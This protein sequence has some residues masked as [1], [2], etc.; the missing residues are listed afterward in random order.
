M[1]VASG[2]ILGYR[3]GLPIVLIEYGQAIL[4]LLVAVLLF[5]PLGS[6]WQGLIGGYSA[7]ANVSALVAL[8]VMSEMVLMIATLALMRRHA[9]HLV[10]GSVNPLSRAAGG[11]AG[12]VKLAVLASAVIILLEAL[13]LSGSD[14]RVLFRSQ[15]TRASLASSNPVSRLLHGI[16]GDDLRHGLGL[17]TIATDPADNKIVPLN[18]TTTGSPDPASESEML[19][20]VN[21]ERQR[22]GLNSLTVN[23]EAQTVARAYAVDMFAG[24]YFSHQGRDGSTPF[25]R[26][27][28]NKV[29][30]GYA[31]ENLA[32]APQVRA[33]H[34][35]LMESPPHRANILSKNYRTVGIGIIKSPRYGIMVVQVFTD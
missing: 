2:I 30:F 20:L 3:R 14:Q 13:P 9:H 23:T 26:L 34:R 35:G 17:I 31:G 16:L 15:L 25:D 5:Q 28:R 33:A 10:T 21:Q 11:F 6:L 7:L 27:T 22:Q 24:G 32:L 19:N 1:M 18:F 29:P 8:F 12:G 4:A